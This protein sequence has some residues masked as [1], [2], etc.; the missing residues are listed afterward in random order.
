MSNYPSESEMEP[1]QSNLPIREE[2]S[3]PV[4]SYEAKRHESPRPS[5]TSKSIEALA[6]SIVISAVIVGVS[7]VAAAFLYSRETTPVKLDGYLLFL[8]GAIAV[9]LYMSRE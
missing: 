5:P 1:E 2:I 7:L 8:G 4:P 6:K 3:F 9:Y